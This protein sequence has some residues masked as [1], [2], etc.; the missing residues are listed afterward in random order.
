ME[1]ADPFEEVV[2]EIQAFWRDEEE[3]FSR[4]CQ[5]IFNMTDFAHYTELAEMAD[6]S[7]NTA[8]KHLERLAEIGPVE[9]FSAPKSAQYRRNEVYIE[10]RVLRYIVEEYPL[11]EI[12][13]RVEALE[14]RQ[15]ELR[16]STGQVPRV[17][18]SSNL[19]SAESVGEGMQAANEL[20]NV[21]RR[22]R[23]YELARQMI[24]NEGHLLSRPLE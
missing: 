16:G 6:C 9:R 22:I 18:S 19:K 24:Q 1:Y 5:T 2:E 14:K 7:P 12:V 15:D 8:K 17:V 20:E 11:D 4:V 23:L 10:W 21:R 3:S 13:E